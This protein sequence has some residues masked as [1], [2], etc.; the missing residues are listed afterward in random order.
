MANFD[1]VRQAFK[2]EVDKLAA[3]DELSGKS[4]TR[5]LEEQLVGVINEN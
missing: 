3:K 4:G 5:L 1:K 2:E